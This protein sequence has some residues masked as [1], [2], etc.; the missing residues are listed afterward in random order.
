[1]WPKLIWHVLLISTVSLHDLSV[2]STGSTLSY[3]FVKMSTT[4]VNSSTPIACLVYEKQ[5]R[6]LFSTGFGSGILSI[7]HIFRVGATKPT[8]DAIANS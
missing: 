5:I 7:G 4:E 8:C 6:I 1:M 2:I 3:S